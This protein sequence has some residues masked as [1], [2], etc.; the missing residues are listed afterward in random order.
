M[1]WPD[2]AMDE[3]ITV[4]RAKFSVPSSSLHDR[5]PR[6]KFFKRNRKGD[7]S[8]SVEHEMSMVV[9]EKKRW[10]DYEVQDVMVCDQEESVKS[11]ESHAGGRDINIVPSASS[12]TLK[13]M[14]DHAASNGT[15]IHAY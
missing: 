2:Y 6:K 5:L 4:R 10:G 3:A 1:N 13:D 11:L 14:N 7:S 8:E 12:E 9:P 15:V